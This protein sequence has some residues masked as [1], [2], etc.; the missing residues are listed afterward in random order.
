MRAVALETKRLFMKD[1]SIAPVPRWYR[2]TPFLGRPPALTANQWKVLGLVAVVSLFE[3]YDVYLF[4]LNLKQIQSDLAVGD[5]NLGFLGALV[6]AGSFLAVILAVAADHWGRRS[7]L[8]ITVWGYTLF[9]GATAFAP[10][11][12]TFVVFQFL[13]RGFA[14]AELMIAAVVITEEFAPEHRGW[15]IGALAA[16]QA[17]GAGLASL[18]FGFVEYLPYGWR[19]LYIVGL[20]PLV[21]IAYWRRTLPETSRFQNIAREQAKK[22]VILPML[23]LIRANPKRVVALLSAVFAF[24]IA[25]STAAFFAPKYLQDVHAWSTG[26][27]AILMVCGG[28]FAIVGNPMAGWLSDTLGR[29]PVTVVFSIAYTVVCVAFYTIGGF[30]TP[31]LWVGLIFFVMGTDVTLTSL[32]AELFPTAQRSTASGLKGIVGTLAAILGLSAV[33]ALYLIVHSNWIAI[34]I[35]CSAALVVPFV[36]WFFIPETAGRTLEDI[37]GE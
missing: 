21:L 10:N 11:A 28:A 6:R 1:E 35:L 26:D 25:S 14:S 3:Q 32:G 30:F 19:S 34:A 27:V 33:S 36:V 17:C 24:G 31:L 22:N 7:M 29:R 13:S 8:M 37:N 16:I 5:E 20:F 12:E 4:A 9:T 2:L 23:E 18:L 15:G